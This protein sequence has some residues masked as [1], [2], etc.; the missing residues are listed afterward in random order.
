MKHRIRYMG[1]SLH[2]DHEIGRQNGIYEA[3]FIQGFGD[4]NTEKDNDANF[5]YRPEDWNT[6]SELTAKFYRMIEGC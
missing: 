3:I 2:R 6:E 5:T 4:W 1:Q